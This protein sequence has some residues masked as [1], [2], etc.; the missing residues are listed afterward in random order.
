M[1][2]RQITVL[3]RGA[4]L[5]T[6]MIAVGCQTAPPVQEMSDARQ[7]LMAAQDAGAAEKAADDFQQAV[8]Y[9]ESAEKAL[10]EKAYPRARR[11]A[12][13]AKTKALEALKRSDPEAE[14]T[15]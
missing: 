1:P 4:L 3:L 15:H 11:D 6:L 14:L 2:V 9:L 7:A 13:L 12:V 5:A 8:R 10:N